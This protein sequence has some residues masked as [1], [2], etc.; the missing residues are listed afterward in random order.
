MLQSCGSPKR[1]DAPPLFSATD[2]TKQ[3][4]E[5]TIWSVATG[6]AIYRIRHSAITAATFSRDGAMIA[7]SGL[8]ATINVWEL[9]EPKVMATLATFE[10]GT[11]FIGHRYIDTLPWS[12]GG[13]TCLAFGPND[14]TLIGAG[15]PAMGF[16]TCGELIFWSWKEPRAQQ[17]QPPT[18]KD[19]KR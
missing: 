11:E 6:K 10:Q 8:D 9:K 12:I 16:N 7:T 18:G 2:F 4:G 1:Y 15:T 17:S 3:P 13:A 5:A 14:N 19:E